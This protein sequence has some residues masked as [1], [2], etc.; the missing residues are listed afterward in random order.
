M[1]QRD[2]DSA[3]RM[4][5]VRTLEQK[6]CAVVCPSWLVLLDVSDFLK[7]TRAFFC[8]AFE[9]NVSKRCHTGPRSNNTKRTKKRNKLEEEQEKKVEK[10]GVEKRSRGRRVPVPRVLGGYSGM[11]RR[12]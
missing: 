5:G 8:A 3:M 1:R 2:Q 10:S 9:A 7:A 12:G 11:R 6:S 4:N